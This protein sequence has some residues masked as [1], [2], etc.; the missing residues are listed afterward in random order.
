MRPRCVQLGQPLVGLMLKPLELRGAPCINIMETR[1]E[2][3]KRCDEENAKY[4]RYRCTRHW[5]NLREKVF[6]REKGICQGCNE[7]SI[8]EIHHLIYAHK[9][10]E[11][12]YELVGLCENCHRK[13][14]FTTPNWN[15][16]DDDPY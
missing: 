15:P 9:Y 5:R 16:W 10:D 8:E 1:D 4:S 3:E 11:L 13:A 2:K 7:A 14:H 6:E 12:L